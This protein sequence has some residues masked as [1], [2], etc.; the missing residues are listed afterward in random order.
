L[1]FQLKG[2]VTASG[3]VTSTI[4]GSGSIML[5]SDTVNSVTFAVADGAANKDLLVSANLDNGSGA[6]WPNRQTSSLV[7]TGDGKMVLGGN[8]IYTGTTTISGGTLQIGDGG[9]TGTLGLNG[10][11]TNNAL[12]VF[13]RN[14][15]MTVANSISGT[16]SLTQA[17]TG[18]TTLTGDN[19]YTGGTTINA[20]AL[21]IGASNRLPDVG[22]VTINS[23]SVFDLGS[24]GDYVGS[25]T[26]NGNATVS[27][28]SSLGQ[29]ILTTGLPTNSAVKTLTAN[30]AG[31]IVTA[32]IGISSSHGGVGG[33]SDLRFDVVGAPDNLTLSGV[34]NDKSSDGGGTATR[35]AI[36]KAG[37]GTLLLLGTN[38]YT[39]RTSILEGTVVAANSRALGAG[40]V[41]VDTMTTV[42]AGAT[43]ALQ[44]NISMDEHMHIFGSGVGGLGAIRNLSGSNALTATGYALRSDVTL[45]ADTGQL[46]I[47]GAIGQEGGAYGITK[48]GTGTL[49]LS[50]V[51]TY[52]GGTRV[53]A[54]SLVIGSGGTLLNIGTDLTAN[55]GGT[56][57][58]ARGDVL[59]LHTH[60][61]TMPVVLNEGGLLQNSG[62]VF[63]T[64]GALNL[65]GGTLQANDVEP[66]SGQSFALKGAVTVTGNATST[67][68]GN[69]I[70]LGAAAVTGTTFNVGDGASETDLLVTGV[71]RD[72]SGATFGPTQVS[73][74]TKTGAGVMVLTGTN[75]YTGTTTISAGTL[76][77]GNGGTSGNLGTGNVTND[78]TLAINRGNAYTLGNIVSGTGGLVQLGEGTTT[79]TSSNTYT[80]DTVVNAG[81]LKVNGSI[82][83]SEVTVNS[84]AILSGSGTVGG[85]SGAGSINPGNSPGILTAPWIDPSDGM[86][87]NFEI[88]DIKPE[89]SQATNSANDVL[90]LTAANP[91]AAA[92]DAGNQIN[93]YFNVADFD[94]DQA[95]LGGIYTDDQ[96]DFTNLVSNAT[97]NYYIQD[98]EG[99]VSYNG[100]LYSV[101][102]GYDIELGTAL[103][104]ANF[105]DGTVNGRIMQFTV[106]PEP[107]SALLVLIAGGVALTRR[108][109]QPTA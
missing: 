70:A 76:Q 49:L 87:L 16:G 62:A 63:N 32:G 55:N 15:A 47:S 3:D 106:V 24:F 23:G 73:S 51:N 92:M 29:L 83:S 10:A 1:A 68:A 69:G 33:N 37:Q 2:T 80:G 44:G 108:R 50:G 30:G 102:T 38:T 13:N 78:S 21:A 52:S 9:T 41:F 11:V 31:N 34:I 36:S 101:L 6:A 97:F 5:G 71:L 22:Q 17:G 64:L 94:L 103:D 57:T 46:T 91:F 14:N 84:G 93:V 107:S 60:N 48:V 43:L 53:N 98:D 27:G 7:K 4:G 85:I 40:G 39:G 25:L 77:V 81:E 67:I 61:I 100:I 28:T 88:T 74:F 20:G 45:G 59:G 86:F 72:G 56:I 95:F 19:T 75:T 35:G 79:L 66:G 65:N 58:F 104:T 8:N 99:S 42:S 96:A 12:L 82:A 105:A 26:M 18:T 89:Y 54:G 90:R 109:R